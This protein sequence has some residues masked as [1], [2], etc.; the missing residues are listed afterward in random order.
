[1]ALM[2]HLKYVPVGIKYSLFDCLDSNGD[3]DAFCDSNLLNIYVGDNEHF[4]KI[5]N[6]LKGRCQWVD[7]LA[8]E[9]EL[10][11]SEKAKN[12]FQP[13]VL[14][15]QSIDLIDFKKKVL[16]DLHN[17]VSVAYKDDSNADQNIID[18]IRACVIVERELTKMYRRGKLVSE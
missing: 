5:I 9:S 10:H 17:V 11:K 4:K 14:D 6:I 15:D 7:M 2:K 16:K 18:V 13:K 12:Y 1:M 3:V 8:V